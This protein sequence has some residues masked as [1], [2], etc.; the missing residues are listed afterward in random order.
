M[1]HVDDL[2][3][4]LPLHLRPVAKETRQPAHEVIHRKRGGAVRMPPRHLHAH[5]GPALALALA[6]R[7]PPPLAPSSTAGR[8][9]NKVKRVHDGEAAVTRYVQQAGLHCLNRHRHTLVRITKVKHPVR[10]RVATHGSRVGQHAATHATAICPWKALH[11]RR[12]RLHNARVQEG[13]HAKLL[14]RIRTMLIHRRKRPHQARP[15]AV[16]RNQQPPEPRFDR[17]RDRVVSVML[18]ATRHRSHELYDR[19]RGSVLDP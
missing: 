3:R 10:V 5:E 2:P 8:S 11:L 7:S 19:M 14:Q 15:P 13:T 9:S 18:H 4:E 16:F 6:R 17:T 1:L 12:D